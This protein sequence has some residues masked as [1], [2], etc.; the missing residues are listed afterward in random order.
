MKTPTII[1]LAIIAIIVIVTALSMIGKYNSLVS[2]DEQVSNE[3]AQVEN[4][5]KR[6][7]DLIPNL[8]NTVKGYAKHEQETL[9]NVVK[10]RSEATSTNIDIKDAE[11]MS[12]YQSQQDGIS[13]A[14]SKLM[15]V[16]ENYPELKANESFENLQVNLEGTE[17]RIATARMNYNE[18]VKDYNIQ[19]RQFP[20]N[21]TAKIFGF[22]QAEMLE[23][24]EEESK[25]PEVNF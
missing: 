3:W 11:A 24:T 15:V 19:T 10:A 18:K 16:V 7:A 17:N 5:Y 22:K 8:V 25:T 1:T 2:L 14:L 9:E 4:Q 12:V 6:R 21:I 23:I 20:G 13:S